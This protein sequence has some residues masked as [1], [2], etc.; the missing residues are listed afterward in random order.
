VYLHNGL[1][2]SLMS[3]TPGAAQY[4]SWDVVEQHNLYPLLRAGS[5]FVAATGLGDAENWTRTAATVETPG[6]SDLRFA[7]GAGFGAAA[8]TD[9]TVDKTGP[10]AGMEKFP[11]FLQG[12]FHRAL[13]PRP[14]TF[15][16]NNDQAG[17]FILR[18]S[19]VAKAGAHV[20]MGLDG[21]FTEKDFP[22][23]AGDYAPPPGQGDVQVDL[24][25]GPHTITIENTGKDWVVIRDLIFT[26]YTAALAA[27]GLVGRQSAVFWVYHRA[28]VD[29]PLGKETDAA[30][31]K[32]L[33]TG[34]P[35]GHYRVTW[36]DTRAGEPLKTDKV[37]AGKGSEGAA[38]DTPVILRDAAVYLVKIPG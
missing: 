21:Q 29:A 25:A 13:F 1:W 15:H 11:S 38:L 32:L 9:F 12:D 23:A 14:L 22:P 7:P 6:R 5:R 20:R 17:S 28:N 37:Y 27:I 30:A 8:Q 2:A 31:G 10:P 3:G 35:P 24:P 33:V 16:I 36:W 19:Q 34:L 4:W 18:L 26:H